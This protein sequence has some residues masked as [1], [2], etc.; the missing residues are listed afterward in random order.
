MEH[1]KHFFRAV[2]LLIV[3]MV[4]YVFA[5]SLIFH[6]DTWIPEA[7]K[8]VRSYTPV[9]GD[10]YSCNNCHSE[11]AKTKAEAGHRGVPC[12]SCH[13]PLSTH[14]KGKKKIAPMIMNRSAK[15]CMRCHQRLRARPVKFPQVVVANHL[16]ENG[17]A[18]EPEICIDC[19]MPHSPKL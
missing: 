2:L 3:I 8:M 11:V 5:R 10:L 9:F 7:K 19:H 6:P 18:F 15:L 14:A 17:V 1:Q 12:E 13:A 4:I 16:S